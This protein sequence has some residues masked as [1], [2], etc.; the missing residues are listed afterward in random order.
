MEAA[1]RARSAEFPDAA[2]GLGGADAE[3]LDLLRGADGKLPA[4]VFQKIRRMGPGRKP[5]SGNRR[6]TDLAKLIIHQHGDPVL[7]MASLY[8]MPFDQLIEM[9]MA[10]EGVPEREGRLFGMMERVEELFAKAHEQGWGEDRLKVLEKAL[11]AVEKAAASLKAKPG[12]IALKAL[13]IVKDA[14]KEVGPYVQSKK[15]T[16]LTVRQRVDGVIFMPAP[17]T[18]AAD[19]IDAVMRRTAEAIQNGEITPEQITD[20]RFNPDSGA[21]EVADDGEGEA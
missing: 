13:G 21:F 5:G 10:A 17:Q 8:S 9:L 19:P 18:S 6:N 16:E 3:Q 1:F 11:S 7:F 15:P 4:D 14:A 20:L 2:A 12:E